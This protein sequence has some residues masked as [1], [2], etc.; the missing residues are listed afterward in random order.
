MSIEGPI[1]IL[2]VADVGATLRFYQAILGFEY[3]GK[4]DSWASLERG[5]AEVML[6]LPNAHEP[7][8]KPT[9]T[10]SLYFRCDDVDALWAALKDRA[11]VAYPIET[12]DNGMREFAVRDNNGYIIEFG[13]P[14]N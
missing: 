6:S 8:T 14:V 12:F 7:F 13:E 1:P 3:A 9:F 11:A 5:G 4:T 2:H 10:G